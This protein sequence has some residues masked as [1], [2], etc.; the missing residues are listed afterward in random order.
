MTTIAQSSTVLKEL[1]KLLAAHGSAFGQDRV[2]GRIVALVLAEVLAVARHRVTDLLR[3]LGLEGEEWSAWYRVWQ[4]PQRFA[5]AAAAQVL[6]SETLKEVGI[7]AVYA[8]GVDAVGVPRESRKLEG[9]GWM[10]CPR[11]PPWRVSIHR[12]QR[13]VNASWLA[14]LVNGFSRAI[15]LRFL[16]AFPD[17]AVRQCHDAVKEQ[18]A[19]LQA[20]EWTRQQLDTAGREEQ[21][22]LCLGDAVYDKPEF[23]QGL[24]HHTVALVR[25][26]KNR[27][28]CGLPGPYPG[29]GRRRIYGDPAPAPQSYLQQR[30]GW[31]NTTLVVRG[32]P[33]RVVYR[34]EGP[35]LRRGMPQVPLFLLIVRG[36]SWA[37]A[38]HTKRRLPCYYLVNAKMM[39]GVWQLPLPVESLLTWAWQRWEMEVTH[40]ELKSDFGLGDKQAFHP[41]AAVA[42]VQ[43]SAWVYA[44]L[45]LVG[46]RLYGY[47]SPHPRRSAWQRSRPRRATLITLLNACRLELTLAPDFSA[48]FAP[49]PHNWLEIEP[50]FLAPRFLSPPRAS[51]SLP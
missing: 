15:P 31:S 27:A 41:L 16:P 9:S 30:S 2:Y 21:V 36:Q 42:S 24:P 49:S 35:F 4:R 34:V 5:E 47:G 29:R 45:V 14:P 3:A 32:R 7:E 22:L 13:F 11:N 6:F 44:L 51:P 48:L 28:L 18:Q 17:K 38:G 26:A 37:R 33:R 12:A 50:V 23:W 8:M 19:G 25:T 46:L 10:K 20:V 1:V 39:D 40:R 43:W